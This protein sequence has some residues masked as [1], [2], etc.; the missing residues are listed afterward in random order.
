MRL[1]VAREQVLTTCLALANR[2]YLAATGGN[3]ALRIDE[4]QFLVTP[5]AVD[6]YAMT[7][8]DLCV[9]R[10]S[11]EQWV[12]GDRQPSVE[13]GLHAAV[14]RRRPDCA[15]SLHTHQPIASAYGLLS[16]PLEIADA[17]RRTLLGDAVPCV[18]YAPSGTTWL[19]TQASAAFGPAHHACLMRNHGVL[20]V[21]RDCKTA[22]A[23]VV[24]LE[25]ECALYF[26]ARV[27][28]TLPPL[29][30]ALVRDALVAEL[31]ESLR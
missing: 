23:R 13:A 14:F 11:D 18:Q 27:S 29:A 15:V 7:P 30:A 5:S 4:T 9:V 19:A 21:G 12:A 17:D 2:G 1:P 3:V 24:A 16:R 8:S 28:G 31:G 6:Y 22:I 26:R 10:I 25:A 20:C